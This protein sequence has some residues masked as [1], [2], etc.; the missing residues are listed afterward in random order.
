MLNKLFSPKSIA[1]IGASREKT[2]LGHTILVNILKYKYRG[3]VYPVNP[4]AK[5]ILGLVCYPSV[6]TIKA[7]VDLAVV[8]VPSVVVPA[9]LVECGKKKITNVIVVSAGFKEI[10]GAG[11]ELEEKIKQIAKDYDINLLGPNC[12]GILDSVSNLNASFA[13]GMIQPGQVAFM[14]QSGAICTAMLDWAKLNKLGFSRFISL[15]NKAGVTENELL[16]FL[17]SDRETDVILAYLEGIADGQKFLQLAKQITRHKPLI[18]LKAGQSAQAQQAIASHTGSLAGADEAVSAAFKQAGVIRAY[19]LGD[20]FNYLKLFSSQPLPRGNRVAVVAN[21]GGPAVMTTDAIAQ[22]QLIMAKF[23]PATTKFLKKNLPTTAN[24][25]NPVDVVGD[26]RADRYQV[27]L[28]AVLADQ[29]VDGVIVILTPQTVTEIAKTAQLIVELSKKYHKPVVTS[30]IGGERVQTGIDILDQHGIPD[31][32]YPEQAVRALGAMAEY[33]KTRKQENR[34]AK[35]R[36][37][38]PTVWHKIQKNLNRSK[39][40]VAW[41]DAE[42]ILQS[43]Q[44]PLVK[45]AIANNPAAAQKIAQKFG[46]P[47]VLKVVAPKL[48]H[49]TDAGGVAV[50]LKT[51]IDVQSA[52]KRLNKIA[53]KFDGQILVQPMLLGAKEI[54]FGIKRDPQFGPLLM[55]GLGGIYVN[56]LKDV[57]FRIVPI[58]QV[59]ALKMIGEIRAFKLL[60]GARGE[61]GVNLKSIADISVKLGQLASDFPQIKEIDINPAMATDRGCFA[62]DVR[63]MV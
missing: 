27:A 48:I 13:D 35:L 37:M 8:I 38:D 44:I 18:I 58:D 55:F 24:I 32:D 21:A 40:Q 9:V 3:R 19:S 50:N 39:V 20:L 31:Y 28:K 61:K 30:F 7:E 46:Y 6:L 62:V 59:E 11:V 60:Q 2:K 14:S 41:Q 4:G 12:L 33:N 16:E 5:K 42:E 63:I 54:I 51:P 22:S 29:A 47:V 10:G 43:Y 36:A 1:V 53:K 25:H 56:I 57:T 34:K 45:S 26:A 15:G 17:A 52:F 23:S 49:K